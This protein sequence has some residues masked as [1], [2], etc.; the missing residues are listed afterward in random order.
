MTQLRTASFR[1]LESNSNVKKKKKKMHVICFQLGLPT[2]NL[3]LLHFALLR[4]TDTVFFTNQREDPPPAENDSLYCSGLQPN[5][6]Y[7]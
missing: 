5:P 2:Y 7:L 6:Q 1:F 4:Y 3:F